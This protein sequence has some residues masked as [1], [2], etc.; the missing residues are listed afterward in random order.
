MTNPLL[1]LRTVRHLRPVQVIG[2]TRRVAVELL[3]RGVPGWGAKTLEI[4]ARS[5]LRGGLRPS[6]PQLDPG[7]GSNSVE[8][9][10]DGTLRLIEVEIPVVR[11]AIPWSDP[12]RS[13]LLQVLLHAMSFLSDVSQEG[14]AEAIDW[15]RACMDDWIR[16]QTAPIRPAWSPYCIS[17][18]IHSWLRLMTSFPDPG[19]GTRVA[20][21]GAQ[22][23]ALTQRLELDLQGNHLW[24]NAVALCLS[25]VALEGA[26]PPIWLRRGERLLQQ[27]IDRQL[28]PKG[29][30][31]ERSAMYHALLLSGLLDLVACYEAAGR[32]ATLWATA[33]E[34][35]AGWLAQV[36]SSEGRLPQLN[37]AA[38]GLAP[39]APS[40][41]Q[42]AAAMGIRSPRPLEA[43]LEI[44]GWIVCRSS[45]HHL[46]FD[47]AGL[48]LDEQPGHAHADTTTFEWTVAGFPVVVDPGAAGYAG[49][50]LRAWSR[51]TRAH[52]V[53]QLDGR[54]SAEM[55]A[56]FRV[57]RRPRSVTVDDPCLVPTP[58]GRAWRFGGSHDG[59]GH[60]PGSPVIERQLCCWWIDEGSALLWV[61]DR[62]RGNAGALTSRLPLGI[63]FS[64]DRRSG[65]LTGPASGRILASGF[66]DLAVERGWVAERFGRWAK[67]E[68]VVGQSP[69]MAP[70]GWVL[71][72]GPGLELQREGDAVVVIRGGKRLGALPAPDVRTRIVEIRT[73]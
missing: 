43:A 21:L 17:R 31:G 3:D 44:D 30:H 20:S 28:L 13:D 49:D 4:G 54:D 10:L 27:C 14:T 19:D 57:G 72:V 40:L 32:D 45:R 53:V 15:G 50:R 23:A 35:M 26:S 12:D 24:E 48:G 29:G 58:V 51:S 1:L 22:A 62:V 66:S 71:A 37:D 47:A 7:P 63:G 61:A 18:R 34:R 16:S 8:E 42:A 55:W 69:A 33:A 65:L 46:V 56:T 39:T 9:I 25:G 41:L 64:W 59:Y 36:V 38:P 11:G 52:A 73:P 67:T 70:T 6:W 60:L 2:R 5:T 68:V